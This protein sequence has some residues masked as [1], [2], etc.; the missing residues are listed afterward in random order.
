MSESDLK[1]YD[2]LYQLPQLVRE[3]MLDTKNIGVDKTGL[4][5]INRDGL[6]KLT[7]LPRTTI[8]DSLVRLYLREL[9]K[10]FLEKRYK[11]GRPKNFFCL[12]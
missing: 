5:G 2:A 11:K 1:V 12:I 3:E 6:V 8:Y 9:V 10:N 7:G 4:K